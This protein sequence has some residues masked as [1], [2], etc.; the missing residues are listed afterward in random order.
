MWQ[1]SMWEFIQAGGVLMA[2]ILLCSILTV[3]IFIEKFIFLKKLNKEQK[4]FVNKLSPKIKANNLVAAINYCD[5]HSFPVA[6]ILKAGILKFGSSREDIKESMQD[7]SHTEIPKL[8]EKLNILVYI[9]QSAPLLGLLGTVAGIANSFYTIQV[10]SASLNPV[11]AA[12]L[13]AGIWQALITTITGLVVAIMASAFYY[14]L[15]HRI[16]LVVW[17]MERTSTGFIETLSQLSESQAE[18]E[19]S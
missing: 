9:Y 15:S 7:I 1:M 16:T 12:D 14:Y 5:A 3:A 11:T 18:T 19:L 17:D 6:Y 4:E 2:P 10:R 13:A 8:E